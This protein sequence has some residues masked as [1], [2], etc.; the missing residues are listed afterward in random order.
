MYKCLHGL[1]PWYMREIFTVEIAKYFSLSFR[2]VSKKST[3][4]VLFLL[5]L[6]RQTDSN[7]QNFSLSFEKVS[8]IF[9]CP[10]QGAHALS[11][12]KI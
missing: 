5:V 8:K 9:G 10:A 11:T 12:K 6:D 2:K 3:C 7:F 4:L 1:G